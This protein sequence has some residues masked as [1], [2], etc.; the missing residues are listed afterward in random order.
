M[1]ET[2]PVTLLT[3]F[4]GAGKTTLLNALLRDPA[5]TRTAVLVNEFGE[6]GL[7]HFLVEAV[8][9]SPPVLLAGGCLCCSVGGDLR[10]ALRAMLPRAR[11]DEITRI[12]I[13]TT[14]LAD[15]VPVMA[16]LMQDAA[17][18]AAY[19]L[20][21]IITVVDAFNADW[22][23]ERHP[24][25]GRQV[26]V[27]DRIVL[28][29]MDLPAQSVG[30]SP[31]SRDAKADGHSDLPAR[32]RALNAHA[33]I[34]DVRDVAVPADLLTPLPPVAAT[35]PKPSRF[36]S[37]PGAEHADAFTSVSLT[38]E[39][40]VATNELYAALRRLLDQCGDRILRIKGIVNLP[41]DSR[42]H[43]VHAVGHLLHPI[44]RL[45]HWPDGTAP[46]STLV[47]I[48]ADLP[49]QALRATLKLLMPPQVTPLSALPAATAT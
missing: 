7:D 29:K 46:F 42:P 14:G 13:E 3:G 18:A 38:W 33:P 31:R 45:A 49:E 5:L 17:I 4:L 23:L 10:R 30:D 19:R 34:I 47:V 28:T 9:P 12:V 20:D 15:P 2:T 48:A 22:Q 35:V 27:A 1:A 11:R 16:T 21:G 25:A 36:R 32:L 26:A 39:N 43:A 8:D 24:E 6:A 37:D 44:A 40:P 41:G